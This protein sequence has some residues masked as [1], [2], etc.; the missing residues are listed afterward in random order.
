[1]VY[2]LNT[3]ISD[4]KIVKIALRKIFGIG[5]QKAIEICLSLGISP[6]TQIKQLSAEIKNKIIIYIE[7]NII[8]G[9]NLKHNLT[10]IK[11]NQIRM[12]CYKV[13]RA[14]IKLQR[15]CQRTHTNSKTVKKL[16]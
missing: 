1:M 8:I 13:Q 4:K 16:K 7:K 12:K 9:N 3:E 15:R 14:K 5:K 10:Q 6:K 2:I 11:E